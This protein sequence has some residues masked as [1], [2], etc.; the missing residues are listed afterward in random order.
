MM[1]LNGKTIELCRTLQNNQHK[2]QGWIEARRAERQDQSFDCVSKT[3]EFSVLSIAHH[4][5]I[6]ISQHMIYVHF[7]FNKKQS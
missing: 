1:M 5:N 3:L 6:V 7:A 4:L 2:R